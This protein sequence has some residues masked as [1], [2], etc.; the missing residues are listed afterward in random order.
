MII[1]ERHQLDRQAA[2]RLRLQHRVPDAGVAV[3]GRPADD[4]G[5]DH[6]AAGRQPA[7]PVQP[8]VRTQDAV[9]GVL[10]EQHFEERHRRGGAEQELVDPPRRAVDE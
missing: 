2:G 3:V 9:A 8:G 4:S 5:V 7:M 1:G 6:V 10:V